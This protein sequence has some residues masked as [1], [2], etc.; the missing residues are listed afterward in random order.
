MEIN[1]DILSAE[2]MLF[3]KECYENFLDICFRMRYVI[4]HGPRDRMKYA[5]FR[6]Q[7][8]RYTFIIMPILAWD[9]FQL[10]IKSNKY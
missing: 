1:G 10:S 6:G 4:Y 7:V 8:V 9:V 2:T 3:A 5:K